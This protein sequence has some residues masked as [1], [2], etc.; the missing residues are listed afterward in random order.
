MLPL[1][2][3]C[4]RVRDDHGYWTKIEQYLQDRRVMVT[5]GI[6]ESCAEEFDPE[7]GP[8]AVPVVRRG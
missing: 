2:A 6:C 5:R 7:S 4:H 1:C 3:W 8:P